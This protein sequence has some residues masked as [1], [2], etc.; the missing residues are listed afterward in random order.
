MDRDVSA[1]SQSS[2]SYYCKKFASLNV[3]STKE[4]GNAPHKPILLLAIIDLIGQDIIKDNI[5]FI[6]D[7]LI[8][9]F[10]KYWQVLASGYEGG[11]HY[12]FFHLKNDGFWQLNFRDTFDGLRP[13]TINKLKKGVEYAIIDEELF[14]LIKNPYSRRQLIDTL[15][16][17]WFLSAAKELNDILSI[18]QVFQESAQEE[19][20]LNNQEGIVK[21]RF[22]LRRS[23]V[24]D[25]LFRKAIVYLYNYRCSVC[26]LK[27]IHSL[28]QSIVDGAHIKPF[29]EFY[30]NQV[31]NGISLCKNHHWA[32]DQGLFSIDKNYKILVAREF[33]EESPNNKPLAHFREEQLIL[34]DAEQ[35]RPSLEAIEWHRDNIFKS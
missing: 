7:E 4:K 11:I 28:T 30:D 16:Q 35:H 10:D 31:N 1:F 13:K 33:I 12:P 3:R 20:N 8:N 2:I 18:N 26:G 21:P 6:T 17:V 27:V 34:P 19:V 32:F 22:Y 5:I 23:A 25:A 14:Y 15:I 24:R 9:A 29:A